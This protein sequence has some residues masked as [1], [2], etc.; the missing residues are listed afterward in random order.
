MQKLK[1]LAFFLILHPISFA[2]NARR[3]KKNI[4]Q[5]F[6]SRNTIFVNKSIF[7][8]RKKKNH[9]H[10]YKIHLKFI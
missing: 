8:P 7:I 10:F 6:F 4:F 9:L 5:L 1:K 2:N 3:C